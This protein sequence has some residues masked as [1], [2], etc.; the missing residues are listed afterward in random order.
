MATKVNYS[1][2]SAPDYKTTIRI[3]TSKTTILF[4]DYGSCYGEYD[5]TIAV[6]NSMN[7]ISTVD[8]TELIINYFSYHSPTTNGIVL[9]GKKFTTD[10]PAGY[11]KFTSHGK[12]MIINVTIIGEA[13]EK[14]IEFN[15]SLNNYT[16]TVENT[17]DCSLKLY[18]IYYEGKDSS[19]N[20]KKITPT[21]NVLTTINLKFDYGSVTYTED[22]YSNQYITWTHIP[23]EYVYNLPVTATA[24]ISI[25]DET[26][27]TISDTREITF[28]K[29]TCVEFS[30]QQDTYT[31]NFSGAGHIVTIT[32]NITNWGNIT[33][34][35]YETWGES[36]N[37]L[38]LTTSSSTAI[39]QTKTLSA[40][41][42][43]FSIDVMLTAPTDINATITC[44]DV[45]CNTT[46]TC[47]INAIVTKSYGISIKYTMSDTKSVA[48]RGTLASTTFSLNQTNKSASTQ[49]QAGSYKLNIQTLDITVNATFAAKHLGLF[50]TEDNI[51]TLLTDIADVSSVTSVSK[52]NINYNFAVTDYSI[53]FEIIPYNPATG[54][55][56]CYL[57]IGTNGN[58]GNFNININI[59]K[60]KL[61]DNHFI[62]SSMPSEQL[63]FNFFDKF[64]VYDLMNMGYVSFSIT[65]SA[66]NNKNKISIDIDE[67][68]TTNHHVEYIDLSSYSNYTYSVTT[69]VSIR[70]DA[71]LTITIADY[72]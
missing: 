55:A 56:K 44:K 29:N 27:V 25:V 6:N 8:S 12:T 51:T 45:V 31:V 60:Y 70:S 10:T 47:T 40:S 50:K 65:G 68:L 53:S 49:K 22:N 20:W 58:Y 24:T 48:I 4:G 7:P 59:G 71:V 28:L 67:N 19:G 52:S 34:E 23:Q 14:N 54:H 72:N 38:S 26:G 63:T 43:T 57:N 16:I 42:T 69:D 11:I 61:L 37:H 36:G 32:L 15:D 1:D 2:L 46:K 39:I 35:N 21:S 64:K 66:Q 18:Y 30:F 62:S 5:E 33:E 9:A 41:K 17:G 13:V 3:G